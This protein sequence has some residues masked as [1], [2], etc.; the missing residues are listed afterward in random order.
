MDAASQKGMTMPQQ[1]CAVWQLLA[2]TY[3]FARLFTSF[4]FRFQF[5]PHNPTIR[6]W[7]AAR[8]SIS[9]I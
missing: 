9:T 2:K 6:T 8:K 5:W 1:H 7:F 4:Y 3:R